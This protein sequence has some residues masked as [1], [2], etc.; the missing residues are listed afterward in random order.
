MKS[1]HFERDKAS[2][3]FDIV[4]TVSR[5][6]STVNATINGKSF[7]A[8]NVMYSTILKEAEK[9]D[10]LIDGTD[11]ELVERTIRELVDS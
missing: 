7:N 11:E 10:F 8:K 5:F 9:I 2:K 3:D 1:I 4:S 6:N